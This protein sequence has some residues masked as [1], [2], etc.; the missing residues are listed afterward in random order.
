AGIALA[1]LMETIDSTVRNLEE[2]TAVS[3]L[4]ALGTIP[5]Q[6][7]KGRRRGFLLPGSG[8]SPQLSSALVT[9]SDPRSQAAESYRAL[10]TSI[11]LSSSSAP[12]KVLLVT[13]ALQEE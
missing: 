1:F 11:L 10:R 5:L 2:I 12:P 6:L 13:S 4:P 8:T 9:C 7:D 3:S